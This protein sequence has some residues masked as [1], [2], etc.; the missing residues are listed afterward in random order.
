M[1]HTS[2]KH[3]LQGLIVGAI[4]SAIMLP[5][6]LAVYSMD[7]Y[8]HLLKVEA[9]FVGVG[10]SISA[11]MYFL[12]QNLLAG[13]LCGYLIGRQSLFRYRFFIVL[14]ASI[15]L[16]FLGFLLLTPEAFKDGHSKSGLVNIIVNG[17]L[18][19]SL[20]YAALLFKNPTTVTS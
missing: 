3:I 15:I 20:Y 9:I 18:F 14:L 10:V 19:I 13:A 6:I 5:V 7:D 8:G 1:I 2:K 11:Y 17:F 12:I 4:C 16:G